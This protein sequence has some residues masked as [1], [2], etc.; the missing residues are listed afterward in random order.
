MSFKANMDI[1]PYANLHSTSD[2]MKPIAHIRISQK[3]HPDIFR[4]A[5]FVIEKMFY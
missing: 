4:T 3:R 1:D 5:F 2:K